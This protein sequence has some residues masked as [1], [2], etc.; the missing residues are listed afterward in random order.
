MVDG[1]FISA[2]SCYILT[3]DIVQKTFPALKT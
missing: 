2:K 1:I 3:Q